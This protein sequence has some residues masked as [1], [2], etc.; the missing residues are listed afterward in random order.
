MKK[1]I[2]ISLAILM[3]AALFAGCGRTPTATTTPTATNSP[4]AVGSPTPTMTPALSGSVKTGGST[5][6]EE[7]M[8]AL[9]FQ[10]KA[11]NKNVTI[12]YEANGSGDGIK[13]VLSDK[14]E[15]GHSSRDLKEDGTEDGLVA[16]PYAIDG[17]VVIVHK[18]NTV[19]NLTKAQIKDIYTGKIKNWKDVGGKDELITV[20]SRESTSGTR[21]AFAEIIGLEKKDADG[22]P[23][24]ATALLADK[25]EQNSTG[26]VQ[27]TVEGNAAAIG[28]ISFSSLK[29]VVKA[30]EY[31]GVAISTQTLKD[32]TYALKRNFYLL[33]K[34]NAT[35]SNEAAAFLEFVLSDAGQDIVK[36]NKLLPIK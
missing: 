30:V 24:P 20:V 1:I 18:S 26:N 33:H 32:D 29:D 2:G 31:E 12:E 16:V 34:E 17:I 35:L 4:A 21:T 7:V 8:Q 27:T 5:S 19:T 15:L 23:D 11:D 28:Y 10:F 13:G 6:V 25:I 9:R 36:E 3:M 14:Y 22:N